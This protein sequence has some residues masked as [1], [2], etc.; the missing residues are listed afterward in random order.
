MSRG[1]IGLIESDDLVAW[2]VRPP[3]FAPRRWWDLECPQVFRV[4]ERYYA[5]ASVMEDRTQRYWVADRFEGPY[6]V[7]ADGGVLAPSG[8]YAGRVCRWRGLDLYFCWHQAD[9]DWA[10]IRNSSGKFVPAPLVLFERPDGSL[11][12]RS[13]P[14]W[15]DYRTA[16][17]APPTL[18][19]TSLFFGT[20]TDGLAVDAST[21]M[22][23]VATADEA[24]DFVLEG[25]ITLDAAVGGLAFRL[26]DRGGGY[27]LE[28]IADQS[29]VKL[30]KWLPG[31]APDGPMSWFRYAELQRGELRQPLRRGASLPFKLIVVGPY[32]ECSLGGEVVIATLSAARTRGRVGV[33]A[34]SGRATAD[35]AL[36]PL[37]R[38]QHE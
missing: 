9:Y 18:A 17:P 12:R 29:V 3:L 24:E 1:C 13:F 10:G 7:P 35:L 27:F 11:G 2:S 4:G 25:S 23:V 37:R 19:E 32:V 14:G 28:L 34:E 26:D 15:D 30:L 36:A 31:E 6:A 33:Y 8:H 21:G 5:T 20:P 38:P 22:D 16:E